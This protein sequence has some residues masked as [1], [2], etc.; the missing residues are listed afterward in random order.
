MMNVLVCWL[1]TYHPHTN[2][3]RKGTVTGT[4]KPHNFLMSSFSPPHRIH[5]HLIALNAL[6]GTSVYMK[7]ISLIRA[8]EKFIGAHQFSCL[9]QILAL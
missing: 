4:E 2:M 5:S 1:D 3:K 9:I 7:L 6:Y 8:A